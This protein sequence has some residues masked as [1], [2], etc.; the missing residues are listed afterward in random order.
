MSEDRSTTKTT[1]GGTI[2]M[3]ESI[4]SVPVAE[5]QEGVTRLRSRDENK[6]MI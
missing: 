2:S 5:A 4:S 6:C 1:T 3:F